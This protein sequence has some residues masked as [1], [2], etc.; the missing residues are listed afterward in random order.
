MESSVFKVLIHHDF[1]PIGMRAGELIFYKNYHQ[2]KQLLNQ[3]YHRKENG[4]RG[5]E[6]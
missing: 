4:N 2:L 1:L 6:Y 3:K 5:I